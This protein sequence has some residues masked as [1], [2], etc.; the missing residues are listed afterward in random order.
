M[1][2]LSLSLSPFA[3]NIQI[4][5]A[6]FEAHAPRW[7]TLFRRCG[8]SFTRSFASFLYLRFLTDFFFIIII[9]ITVPCLLLFIISFT[10]AFRVVLIHCRGIC[11][12]LLSRAHSNLC[13][14]LSRAYPRHFP[15]KRSVDSTNVVHK[16]YNIPLSVLAE[17]DVSGDNWGNV[18]ASRGRLG[19][20]FIIYCKGSI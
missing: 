14:L 9:I 12:S 8:I 6:S 11:G 1:L 10:A 19:L 13:F 3:Q 2:S 18:L 16:I 7:E 15:G 5:V 17:L 20:A 4:A